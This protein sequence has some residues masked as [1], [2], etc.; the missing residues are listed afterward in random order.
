MAQSNGV[1]LAAEMKAELL[2][3]VQLDETVVLSRMRVTVAR[4]A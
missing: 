4:A 2:P 3:V 1:A